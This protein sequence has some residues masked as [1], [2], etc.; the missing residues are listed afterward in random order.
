MQTPSIFHFS[1]PQVSLRQLCAL[2]H[3]SY[4]AIFYFSN[5]ISY[6]EI[7]NVVWLLL[8]KVLIRL[9]TWHLCGSPKLQVLL[10]FSESIM[11]FWVIC[12]PSP[13][14]FLATWTHLAPA[15]EPL[16]LDWVSSSVPKKLLP[17]HVLYTVADTAVLLRSPWVLPVDCTLWFWCWNDRDPGSSAAVQWVPNDAATS[18][19]LSAVCISGWMEVSKENVGSKGT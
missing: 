4:I 16:P 17:L 6:S 13:W 11:V 1:R 14:A 9:P 18:C 3:F 15:V 2:A 10:S 5:C 19:L 8:V 12:S 7:I